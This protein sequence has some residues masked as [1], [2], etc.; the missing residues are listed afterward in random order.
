MFFL[1][2]VGPIAHSKITNIYQPILVT[3]TRFIWI[4]SFIPRASLRSSLL[5]WL[6]PRPLVEAT[7]LFGDLTD[8]TQ[9]AEA[10]VPETNNGLE[11]AAIRRPHV[12]SFAVPAPAPNN[13]KRTVCGT[14][15]V[16]VRFFLR[17]LPIP[18]GTPLPNIAVHFVESPSV[19]IEGLHFNRFFTVNTFL[20]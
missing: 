14:G 20:A 15:W 8:R 1:F 2:Q 11:P 6:V 17:I 10:K 16:D 5:L 18:I 7:L 3:I 9:A 12:L 4:D 19:T 13:T